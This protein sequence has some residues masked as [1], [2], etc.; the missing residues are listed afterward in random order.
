M[1][2]IGNIA[3][4]RHARLPAVRVRSLVLILAGP[5]AAGAFARKQATR[6]MPALRSPTSRSSVPF[7]HP[8][9]R[10]V[11]GLPRR[12][13]NVNAPAKNA[14]KPQQ[15]KGGSTLVNPKMCGGGLRK[16]SRFARRRSRPGRLPAARLRNVQ[17]NLICAWPRVRKPA[18][19]AHAG[20]NIQPTLPPPKGGA[21]GRIIQS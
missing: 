10:L 9:P 8:F 7:R 18:G 21:P 12:S 4:R 2:A 3:F 6:V 16:T 17:R 5:S 1:P 14:Q 19:A 15:N 11:P 20:G 13:F